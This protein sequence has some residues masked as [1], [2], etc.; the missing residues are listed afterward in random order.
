M[1]NL[2]LVKSPL[3]LLNAIEASNN[4]ESV[5]DIL[6]L[7]YTSNPRTNYQMNNLLKIYKWHKVIKINYSKLPINFIKEFLQLKKFRESSTIFNDV[8]I[9]DYRLLNF[10]IFP[11]NLKHNKTYLLDDGTSTFT[12]Q[13]F[14]LKDQEEY[15]GKSK[16][17][18]LKKGIAK[19]IFKFDTDLKEKI[20]L[21]T[22]YNIKPHIGQEILHNRYQFIRSYLK[23]KRNL[24]INPGKTY[25]IGAKYVEAKLMSGDNYFHLLK[26]LKDSLEDQKLIYVPHRGE[27][28]SKLGEIEKL[29]Y[30]IE[31]FENIVEAEF[32]FQ[33]ELPGIVCGFTSSVL[34]NIPKIYPDIK[35]KV[36]E[37]D[38]KFFVPSYRDTVKNFYTRFNK[39][40]GLKLYKIS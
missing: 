19:F 1:Q 10:K 32:L 29:G 28:K 33:D 26:K 7:R 9:G 11:I 20:H 36:F 2:F 3:Q 40:E 13:D 17:E 31:F 27:F 38:E 15:D 18:R 6:I 12:I 39:S 5:E 34:V 23:K 25:Y 22:C 14:Y 8:F 21:Y 35:V 24:K 37:V 4:Y 16:I 30:D